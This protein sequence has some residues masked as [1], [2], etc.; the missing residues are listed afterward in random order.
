V[1]GLLL[2][3]GFLLRPVLMV[4][5]G[6]ARIAAQQSEADL[7]EPLCGLYQTS[8]IIGDAFLEGAAFYFL[9]AYL[10]EGS[11]IAL[12]GA[13]FFLIMLLF[14]FPTRTKVEAW[15][16]RQRGLI[17]EEGPRPRL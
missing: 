10:V 17:E 7:T 16:E 5:P 8:M 15:I 1:W 12:A 13:G 14:Q 2:L 9:I 11:P 3:L 4:K 6:G